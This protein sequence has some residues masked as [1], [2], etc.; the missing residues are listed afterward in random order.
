MWVLPRA[1]VHAPYWHRGSEPVHLW[2]AELSGGGIACGV[3]VLFGVAGDGVEELPELHLFEVRLL[4]FGNKAM[5]LFHASFRN[6]GVVQ[7]GLPSLYKTVSPSVNILVLQK[8]WIVLN[9]S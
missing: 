3:I 8:S 5:S 1:F 9:W 7:L 2:A 6:E 4:S